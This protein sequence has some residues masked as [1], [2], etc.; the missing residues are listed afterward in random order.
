M[1]AC[2]NVACCSIERMVNNLG[3]QFL[4]QDCTVL[5]G[6]DGP[7][8]D[9]FNRSGTRAASLYSFFA[10]ALASLCKSACCAS[11]I[12]LTLNSALLSE[13]C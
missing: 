11:R 10:F 13:L 6:N 12:V 1:C 7:E 3:K 2:V 4:E 9:I 5:G 8:C